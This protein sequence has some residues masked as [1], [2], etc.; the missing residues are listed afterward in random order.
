MN[1]EFFKIIKEINSLEIKINALDN[2]KGDDKKRMLRLHEHKSNR[3]ED[4]K[5]STE[6]ANKLEKRNREIEYRIEDINKELLTISA[7]LNS[8]FEEKLQKRLHEKQITLKN[9][10][11]RLEEEAFEIL[12]KLEDVNQEISDAQGFLNGI[13]E[14]IDEILVEVQSDL[15]FK[16]KDINQ[17]KDRINQI[18]SELSD[19]FKK[20]YK[21]LKE[22]APKNTPL[23]FLKQS[24][25]GH[26]SFQVAAKLAEEIENLKILSSCQMCKRILMPE[27]SSY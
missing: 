18:E 14:T 13:D 1:T 23:T 8:V 20:K 11:E 10:I 9:E 26:C 2:L 19:D 6:T 15:M 27:H 17:I 5:S 25:C 22:K 7:Q 21:N 24:R 3:L 16:D 12:E 4:L